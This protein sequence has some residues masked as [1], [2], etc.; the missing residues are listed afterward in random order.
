MASQALEQMLEFAPSFGQTR[1]YQT[2][3]VYAAGTTALYTP[4]PKPFEP[5]IIPTDSGFIVPLPPIPGIRDYHDTFKIDR[6]DN[7]YGGHTTFDIN[8][9]PKKRIDHGNDGW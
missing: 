5:M 4:P 8:G 6:Y 7:P 1:M 9:F 3:D 2:I